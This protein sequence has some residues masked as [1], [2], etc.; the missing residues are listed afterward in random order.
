MKLRRA[1]SLTAATAALLPVAMAAA[2]VSQAADAP[3]PI[4]TEVSQGKY[5]ENTFVTRA[6]GIPDKLTPSTRWTLFTT[7]LTNASSM[8]VESFKL[9]AWALNIDDNMDHAYLGQYIDLQYWDTS[10]H[11]WK[12]LRGSRA[13]VP[14][15]DTVKPRGSFHLQ[16]RLRLRE[17]VP[18]KS[19]EEILGGVHVGATFVNRSHNNCVGQTSTGG[20]F[21]AEK[22]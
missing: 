7:T 9:T 18:M 21:W 4:C 14:A 19:G 22:H 10:L 12:T 3:V 8:E 6:F 15:P 20:Q 2:P 17:D 16:M 1:L 11:L 13:P 5:H